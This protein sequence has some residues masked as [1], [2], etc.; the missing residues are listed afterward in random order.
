MK[1][2]LFPVLSDLE[3][4]R[5]RVDSARQKLEPLSA[6]AEDLNWIIRLKSITAQLS[7]MIVKIGGQQ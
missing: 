4:A 7:R 1:K 2:Y 3:E 5:K 6:C